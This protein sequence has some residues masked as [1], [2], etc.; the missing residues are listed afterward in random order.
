MH[1]PG[2]WSYDDAMAYRRIIN[3]ERASAAVIP[4]LDLG[5]KANA[6]LAAAAPA[7]LAAVRALLSAKYG[8][9]AFDRARADRAEY[10]AR[11]AIAKAEGRL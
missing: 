9:D 5:T 2:P 1:T 6:R 8:G 4:Y 10:A 7:L 11:N 3:S